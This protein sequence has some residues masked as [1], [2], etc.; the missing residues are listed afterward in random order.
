[1]SSIHTGRA[2]R[3]EKVTCPRWLCAPCWL[4]AFEQGQSVVTGTITV[5]MKST[6]PFSSVAAKR[7]L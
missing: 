4:I 6:T 3:M 5:T 1:M 7:A 2:K